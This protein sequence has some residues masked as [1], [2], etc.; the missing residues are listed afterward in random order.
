MSA[1]V[2]ETLLETLWSNADE[3]VYWLVDGA[4][5]P[6][7]SHRIRHGSL[8]FWS[9]YSGQLTPRLRAA[10]PYLVQLVPGHPQTLE[11]LARG[12]GRAWGILLSVPVSLTMAKLRRHLKKHLQVRTE[13]GTL[14]M[15]RFYDPRVL[16]IYL[17]T[18]TQKELAAF[19]GP[20][21]RAFYELNNGS[22][23]KCWKTAAFMI[24]ARDTS[25]HAGW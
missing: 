4:Q 15:F 22:Q 16:S 12:W 20:I 18:C 10:A 6:A 11:L 21:H 17:P 24:D 25:P 7:I 8:K 1:G 5:D 3:Q 19:F 9:L 2:L 14:L 13:D 23:W